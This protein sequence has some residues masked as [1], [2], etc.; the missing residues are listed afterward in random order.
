MLHTNAETSA[1]NSDT[2]SVYSRVKSVVGV[3]RSAFKRRV[4]KQSRKIQRT[5][6]KKKQTM[7]NWLG[8]GF[9]HYYM[10]FL[11]LWKPEASMGTVADIMRMQ[12][13]QQRVLESLT[14]EAFKHQRGND[15]FSKTFSSVDDPRC[16]ID[17]TSQNNYC[18]NTK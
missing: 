18:L 15:S 16:V 11:G 5:F 4:K 6:E 14:A 12:D 13:E 17:L 3:Q 1:G 7:L 9:S 2:T 8:S 10:K